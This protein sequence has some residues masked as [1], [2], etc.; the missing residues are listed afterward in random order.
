M[1]IFQPSFLRFLILGYTLRKVISPFRH[2]DLNET[3]YTGNGWN[4]EFFSRNQNLKTVDITN[5][6]M[7]RHHGSATVKAFKLICFCSYF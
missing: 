3:T 1:D 4:V 7:Y 2:F 6:K 5:L